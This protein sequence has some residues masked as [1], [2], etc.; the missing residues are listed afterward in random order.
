MDYSN[1]IKVPVVTI[2][3][4]IDHGKSSLLDYIRNEKT[5]ENEAG[6]I[7]QH[8]GAYEIEKKYEGA[9]RRITFID[10][11][12]HAAFTSMRRNST[13]ATDI[14]VLIVATDDGFKEQTM[15]AYKIIEE[16][17]I[18]FLVAFTKIDKPTADIEKAKQSMS[19]NGI[20]LEGFGGDVPWIS[21][22]AKTGEGVDDLL[23]LI[24]LVSDLSEEN[25]NTSTEP[26]EGII[27]E[28]D[29][30]PK[31]GIA[32]TLI[33]KNGT[34]REKEF[35]VSESSMAPTRIMLDFTGKQIE[36]ANISQPIRIIGFNSIPSAGNKII[37]YK[38]K[39]DAEAAIKNHIA[40]KQT[41]V[42]DTSELENYLPIIVRANVAGAVDAVKYEIQKIST[43]ALPV[44]IIQ[45]GVGSINESDVNRA[46][47]SGEKTIIASFQSSIDKNA[48]DLANRNNIDVK[49]FNTIYQLVDWV[50]EKAKANTKKVIEKEEKGRAK[51][52]RVFATQKDRS[53]CGARIING[54]FNVGQRLDIERNGEIL[55]E[56]KISSI[57]QN[58]EEKKGVEN[59]GSEFAFSISSEINPQMGDEI[60]SFIKVEK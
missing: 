19:K 43:D 56:G 35:V 20:Y 55:G 37:S 17:K 15:E 28:S 33:I 13:K 29:L 32:A 60:K 54:S 18:P 42:K 3:G 57:Q 40:T 51:I 45:D 2:L 30:D 34:L 23:N 22:S 50:E 24:L 53:V 27:I 52:I 38:S 46:I 10:T 26:M 9:N 11:P 16:S 58:H 41:N 31:I 36:Q 8:I 48:L 7:T 1:N 21:T 59:K 4:H 44:V 12:G 6:G 49:Y 14:V 5:I 39:K 47:T 25:Q